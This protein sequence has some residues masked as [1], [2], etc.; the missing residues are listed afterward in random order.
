LVARLFGYREAP[1]VSKVKSPWPNGTDDAVYSVAVRVS[2]VSAIR[3]QGV[4]K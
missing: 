1:R 2:T 4:M 3:E